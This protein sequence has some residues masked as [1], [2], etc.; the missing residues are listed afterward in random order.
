MFLPLIFLDIY[1]MVQYNMLVIITVLSASCFLR[2]WGSISR[3]VISMLNRNMK[4]VRSCRIL[5][6]LFP[7]GKLTSFNC[8]HL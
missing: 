3:V 6:K 8:Q 1:V 7:L 4:K 2:T 5:D